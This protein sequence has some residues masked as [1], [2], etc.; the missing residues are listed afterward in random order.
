[1]NSD[2]VHELLAS[3]G[4][5]H[6]GACEIAGGGHRILLLHTAHG[7]AHVLR[8]DYNS[9]AQGVQ[10]VL[11]ATLNLLGE[12]FLHLKTAGV[13]IHHTGNLAE[14]Y[15]GAVWDIGYMCFAHERNHVVLA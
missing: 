3:L 12:T 7:H 2:N 10:R 14:A 9:H 1:M 4:V 5:V 13:S 11:Y 6:K 15:Y 8:L